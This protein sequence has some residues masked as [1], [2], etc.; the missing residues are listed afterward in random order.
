MN[1]EIPNNLP[2]TDQNKE[3]DFVVDTKSK[4]SKNINL[5]I[6]SNDEYT[7]EQKE[8]YKKKVE[9]AMNLALEIHKDQKPRP[10][11]PYVNH[12]L[13]VSNRIVEEYGIKDPELV[14]SALLHDSVEDQSKKLA[15][16]LAENTEN[17]SERE[18]ALLFVKNTFGERVS[19]IVSKLSN[20]E[21]ETEGLSPEQ[22][23][24]IYKEHVKEAI[25]DSDVLPIK[26]SDFS[27]NALNLEAVGD[28]ARRLKLSKKYAPVVLEFIRAL[29]RNTDLVFVSKKNS[30]ISK[31]ENSLD[32]ICEFINLNDKER[33]KEWEKGHQLGD[34]ESDYGNEYH[35][36]GA[37][38]RMGGIEVIKN[39]LKKKPFHMKKYEQVYSSVITESNKDKVFKINQLAEKMNKILSN[40]E[41]VNE[42]DF[43][44]TYNE[45]DFLLR[46][47]I[48]L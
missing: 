22:K 42:A 28:P 14:I 23:N 25:E 20:P 43:K 39:V 41:D 11:G 30:I 13:R 26:L 1:L 29:K 9:E 6:D 10:D 12:I 4:L 15:E 32:S 45:L 5:F 21:P 38:Y 34:L 36:L 2:T 46:G 16:L 44:Q 24:N 27:D 31:L 40:S 47:E 8:H 37:G 48:Y 19:K 35:F 7:T 33:T 3:D 17:I 18:K